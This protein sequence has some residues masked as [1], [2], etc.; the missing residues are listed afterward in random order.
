MSRT[1]TL[2]ALLQTLL[3]VI[4]FFALGIVLKAAGYPHDFTVRWNRVA[5]FLR[6]Y[7][8]WLLLL[9]VLWVSFATQA[10]RLNRGIFSERIAYLSG[11]CLSALI[12]AL[13]LYGAVFPY[14]RP[15]FFQVR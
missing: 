14:T 1:T 13:F 3:I 15:F 5:V 4:G 11:L 12:I 7:G 2:L 9:P 8:A 6:E 10:E